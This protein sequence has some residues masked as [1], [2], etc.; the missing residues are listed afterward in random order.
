[1]F[2][3]AFVASGDE[4]TGFAWL[5]R[6][7]A[8]GGGCGWGGFGIGDF[9]FRD[10]FGARDGWFG[11]CEGGGGPLSGESGELGGGWSGGGVWGVRVVGDGS[12]VFA[13]AA[14]CVEGEEPADGDEVEG[15]HDDEG[16]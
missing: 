8:A 11:T 1:M 12:G 4:E 13:V 7:E 9:V 15:E 5:E 16:A 14:P 3:A 10:D 6:V 2:D